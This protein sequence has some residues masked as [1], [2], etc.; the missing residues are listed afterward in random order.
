MRSERDVLDRVCSKRVN[1]RRRDQHGQ[2]AV[3]IYLIESLVLIDICV[4][5]VGAGR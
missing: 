2:H 3:F 1:R 5:S 4:V